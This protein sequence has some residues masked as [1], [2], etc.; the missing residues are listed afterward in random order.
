[1]KSPG[2][3]VWMSRGHEE[4]WLPIWC[5]TFVSFL[6]L[7]SLKIPKR[8][9]CHQFSSPSKP[10]CPPFPDGPGSAQFSVSLTQHSMGSFPA[11]APESPGPSP[12]LTTHP[13]AQ[14]LPLLHSSEPF[15]PDNA[16]LS[17]MCWVYLLCISTVRSTQ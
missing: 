4:M 10:I 9:I 8:T 15:F 7:L 3:W 12:T 5:L 16:Q 6:N 2:D 1:M 17:L 13:C 11:Q 14:L